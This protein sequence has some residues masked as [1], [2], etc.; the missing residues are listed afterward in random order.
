MVTIPGGGFL[1]GRDLSAVEQRIK[2]PDNA[3][4]LA[5]VFSFSYPAHQVSVRP[6][7]LD[8]TEVSNRDYARFVS[9]ARHRA[10]PGWSGG[11]PPTGA[12]DLPVTN[13]SY[14]DAVEYCAWRGKARGDGVSYRLPTEEEWELAARGTG[15]EKARTYPWGNVWKPGLANTRE[16]RLAQPQIVTANRDGASPFGVLNMCGNAA[17]WTATDFKHYPGSDRP[18]PREKGYAGAYQVVR[19]GSFDYV[20]EWG[21]TT[22]RAWARPTV[23]APNIGFRCAADAHHAAP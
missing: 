8:V 22:T 17:E 3:G 5:E 9:E 21:M 18:T 2:A 15:E 14:N 1:M 7:H 13:V 12:E 11:A 16:S 20:K 6:F 19:G 4:H 10:P 23:K